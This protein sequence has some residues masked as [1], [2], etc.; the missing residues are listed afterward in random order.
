[1]F[2]LVAYVLEK[3]IAKGAPLVPL[4]VLHAL[5]IALTV[6][7]PTYVIW[8]REPS[9][10]GSVAV[11]IITCCVFMKLVSW[12]VENARARNRVLH[13]KGSDACW[14]GVCLD[15]PRLCVCVCLCVGRS[16]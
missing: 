16:C 4:R 15:R 13:K 10:G 14:C 8:T 11:L 9:P 1:M 7:Y 3:L 12:V 5:N 2:A 6:C